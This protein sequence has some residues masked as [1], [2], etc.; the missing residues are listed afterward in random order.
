MNKRLINT[1]KSKDE[2]IKVAQKMKEKILNT[3]R[4]EIKIRIK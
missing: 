1:A 2:R 3:K 4:R